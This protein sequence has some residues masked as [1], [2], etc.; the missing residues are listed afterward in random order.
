MGLCTPLLLHYVLLVKQVIYMTQ[1]Y[2][3][4]LVVTVE[5]LDRLQK[6]E[7]IVA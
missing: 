4:I 3:G 5:S 7:A 1:L 2:T 6:M